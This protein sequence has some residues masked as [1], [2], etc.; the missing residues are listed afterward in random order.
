MLVAFHHFLQYIQLTDNH[1]VIRVGYFKVATK[2][3]KE[4]L[5]TQETRDLIEKYIL[6]IVAKMVLLSR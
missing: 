5:S 6:L 4:P 1:T 3:V 2:D